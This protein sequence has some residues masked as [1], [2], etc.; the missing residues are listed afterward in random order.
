MLYPYS[1]LQCLPEALHA[2]H[3]TS[4]AAFSDMLSKNLEQRPKTAEKKKKK[5]RVI[6]STIG[7]YRHKQCK[8]VDTVQQ[9]RQGC[10]LSEIAERLDH[11]QPIGSAVTSNRKSGIFVLTCL[12]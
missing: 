9:S 4:Y 11:V 5:K 8:K 12:A 2:F 3:L 7:F 10:L 1:L 6:T